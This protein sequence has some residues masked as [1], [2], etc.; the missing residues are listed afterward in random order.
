WVAGLQRNLAEGRLR[1]YAQG[2]HPL[3][4]R[5]DTGAHFE[6]L[7]RQVG[8]DGKLHSPVNVIQAAEN[9]GLMDAI[10]RFVVRQAFRVIGGLSQRQLRRLDT[11]SINLSGISLL[12]EGLLAFIVE[13]LERAKVPPRKICFE[14]TE[15]SALA[16]IGE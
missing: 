12:R 9:S 15:T 8:D 5:R 2:I 11:C 1:L 7:V 14:I 4:T 6:I 10:D 16:N 13:E 3:N